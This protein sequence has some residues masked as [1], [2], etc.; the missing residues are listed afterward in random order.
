VPV[1]NA[2]TRPDDDTL[3]IDGAP[4]LHTPPEELQVR[5]ILPPM[6]A[7]ELPA[8][9]EGAPFMVTVSVAKPGEPAL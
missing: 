6:Q 5:E 7:K 9:A 4:L 3:A 1:A 2:A 8:M